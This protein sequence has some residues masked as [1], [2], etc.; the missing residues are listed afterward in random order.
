MTEQ[1]RKTVRVGFIGLGDQGAPMATAIAE[2]GFELTV[3]ARRPESLAALD[4]VA[5]DVAA[6]APDLAAK[7]DVIGL[8]LGDDSDV[9]D[10]LEKHGLL[11]ALK[12]G[13]IIANH[14]TGDP[15]ENERIG[16]LV[17][18]RGG[19]YLDAPV[20]GGRLAAQARTL[21]TFTGGDADA[22]ETAR[23]VFETFSTNVERMGGVGRG[24][25]TKL[26]NNALMMTNQK[27]AIDVLNIARTAGLDTTRFAAA[28]ATSSG[29][30]PS[31]QFLTQPIAV[32]QVRH[33][34]SLMRKDIAH[35]AEA[36]Q[37]YGVDPTVIYDRGVAGIDGMADVLSLI[38]H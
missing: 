18:T 2:G 3:W 10:I 38:G 31:L 26:L 34:Q 21:T 17:A 24:Q 28:L 23:P 22:F 5:H 15:R 33:L 30:S 36:M 13:T 25:L 19:A 14:G 37:E 20:S 1:D 8:C 6:T 29:N 9:R 12:H 35:F 32:G 7:V 11:A 16:Q 27:N 4:G